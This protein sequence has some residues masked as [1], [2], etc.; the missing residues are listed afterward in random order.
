MTE[1]QLLAELDAMGLAVETR[2]LPGT[3][4][5]Y[6]SLRGKLVVI[7]E[8]MS[9]PQRRSTLAHE[10][11]HARRNDDGHQPP[12]IEG[13]INKEAAQLLISPFEYALAE[14]LHGPHVVAIARELEVSLSIVQAYQQ[15]LGLNV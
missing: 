13:R 8:G 15:M 7:R 3:Q 2:F 14:R 10:L 9:Y 5:G 6:Y 4:R 1:D 12:H 11:M